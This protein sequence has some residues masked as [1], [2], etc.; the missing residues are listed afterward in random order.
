M[1]LGVMNCARGVLL[2]GPAV[3]A[4]FSGGY[5]DQP[6][7]WAGIVAVCLF[8]VAVAVCE[9]PLPRRPPG[10]TALLGLALLTAWIGLSLLWAPLSGP[11]TDDLQRALLYLTGLAAAAGLLHSGGRRVVEP[12]LLTGIAL[13]CLY[14][15]SERLA[16]GLVELERSAIAGGRL[17]QPLTYWNAMGALSAMGVVLAARV[18]GDG[19]RSPEARAAAA[20]TAPLLA[21][22]LS[23]SVSR[24][25]I[26]AVATGLVVLVALAADR[27]Q[28]HAVGVVVVTGIVGAVAVRPLAGVTELTGTLGA[29]EGDGL[30]A[31]AVLALLSVE[32][33]GAQWWAACA[34]RSG[35]L[36]A[37]ALP[38]PRRGVLALAGAVLLLGAAGVGV[39]VSSEGERQRSTDPQAGARTRRLASL[40]SERYNYWRVALSSFAAH[41]VAGVGSGGFRAEWLRERPKPVPT[42]D[43]HSLYLETLAELG[44]AGFAFLV[45]LFAGV[46]GAAARA[47]RRRDGVAVGA[48]AALA[49]WAVHAGI[50]WDWEMPALTLVAVVLA[51]ALVAASEEAA[52]RASPSGEG[53]QL[54][55]PRA[56]RSTR[57]TTELTAKAARMTSETSAAARKRVSP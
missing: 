39:A 15:L 3:L 52:E 12:A 1:R 27:P 2:A 55:E 34:E 6:R 45:L 53:P 23:L 7:L 38:R 37:V 11:A 16:P 51:G 47:L 14:G 36:A 26:V 25:A 5:F 10:R 32:A 24:G 50:D 22:S 35:R 40:E 28:L 31:L 4:L 44:F 54:D 48:T 19:R 30:V 29:R 46:A 20:A 21:V 43:A 49:A 17:Q 41:P 42:Q 13:V 9:Q 8:A 33:A 56:D 18:M 57:S